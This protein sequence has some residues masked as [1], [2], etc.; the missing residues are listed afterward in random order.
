MSIDKVAPSAAAA[1][2][3]IKP[4]PAWP[5]AASAWSASRGS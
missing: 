1:V 2:A 5:S 4:D 3:D